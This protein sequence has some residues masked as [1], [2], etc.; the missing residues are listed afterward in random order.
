MR[1][2]RAARRRR[3][4]MLNIT[5][6]ALGS[7]ASRSGRGFGIRARA[8]SSTSN[9]VTEPIRPRW[10]GRRRRTA[11]S[12]ARTHPALADA[13][14]LVVFQPDDANHAF[15]PFK[16][17][18]PQSLFNCLSPNQAALGGSQQLA[19]LPQLPGTP[20]DQQHERDERPAVPRPHLARRR[21]GGAL[22]APGRLLHRSAPSRQVGP[23][24]VEHDR[25][26]GSRNVGAQGHEHACDARWNVF[27]HG[28]RNA[29]TEGV[30]PEGGRVHQLLGD[31]EQCPDGRQADDHDER[32]RSGDRARTT[33]SRRTSGAR[34]VS[35]RPLPTSR[36]TRARSRTRASAQVPPSS[37][38]CSR[39][40]SSRR[41]RAS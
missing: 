28:H 22:R 10:A 41:P 37:A 40:R 7:A 34:P 26:R 14:G 36:S 11:T 4:T 19:R 15:T 21:V 8:R 6:N 12:A 31:V 38:R 9:N 33:R 30:R 24:G 20:V 18:S 32:D 16:G 3:A 1:A 29:H 35:I 23:G 13:N 2:P 25:E 39:T 5:G 17:E 27:C